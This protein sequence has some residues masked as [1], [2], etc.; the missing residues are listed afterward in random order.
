MSPCTGAVGVVFCFPIS[1]KMGIYI[2]AYDKALFQPKSIDIFLIFPWKEYI[3]G[4]Q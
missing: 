1:E 3:V 2:I 4:T